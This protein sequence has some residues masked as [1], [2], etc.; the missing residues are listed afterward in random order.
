MALRSRFIAV[1]IALSALAA[2]PLPTAADNRDKL[3]ALRAKMR[4]LGA[5]L[6]RD[7]G[8]RDRLRVQLERLERDIS[9]GH[10]ALR[11][12]RRRVAAKR[13]TLGRLT[14]TYRRQTE[15]LTRQRRAL[16]RLVRT[17]YRMGKRDFVKM[18]L[19]QDDPAK[20][21]RM[22]AYYRYLAQARSAQI[23]AIGVTLRENQTLRDALATERR[24]LEALQAAQEHERQVLAE[25]QAQRRAALANLE[26]RMGA[27]QA[28]LE[29]LKQDEARLEKLIDQVSAAVRD[30]P[31]ETPA[32]TSF[33]QM[34]GRLGLPVKAKVRARF[35]DSKSR[36]GRWRGVLLETAESAEVRAVFHGRVAFADWLRGFGLLLILDHGNGYMSLYSHNEALHKQVGD[37]VETGESI[38]QAGTS[39]GLDAPGLYF[40]IRH[41]GEPQ[42]P[43]LW[44]NAGATVATGRND[45]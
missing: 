39:G 26:R 32:G 22:L 31:L 29:R 4:A 10:R 14:D 1:S 45:N 20:L 41:N 17:N 7:S 18:L 34:R 15:L 8:K 40:E 2:P 33:A 19:N 13:D 42:N 24:E 11:N 36:A 23:E 35:G 27:R 6:R 3:D 25:R 44:C 9:E 21:G 38:S 28:E 37:W 16:E 30:L 12:T 5:E 43:L